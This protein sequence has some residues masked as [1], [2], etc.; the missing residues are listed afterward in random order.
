L[1]ELQQSAAFS[2]SLSCRSELG[3]RHRYKRI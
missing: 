2:K 3:G 1:D